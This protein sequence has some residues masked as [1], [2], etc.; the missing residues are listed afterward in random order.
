MGSWSETCGL[1]GLPIRYGDPVMLTFLTQTSAHGDD[2]AGTCYSTGWWTPYALP[3]CAEYA[4]YGGVDGYTDSWD[5]Q[6]ILTRLQ[7][8]MLAVGAGENIYHDYAVNPQELDSI[9]TLMRWIHNDRVFVKTLVH[10]ER[11]MLRLGWMM[12]HKRAYEW[13]ARESADYAD[14]PIAFE[15]VLKQGTEWYR[16]G[17]SIAQQAGGDPGAQTPQLLWRWLEGHSAVGEWKRL[18]GSGSDLDGY[19]PATKI[20]SYR[21]LFERWAA[22]LRPV[23]SP[24]VQ[25]LLH[26]MSQYLLVAR[27]MYRL[28]KHWSPQSGKGSQT[29]DLEY[30]QSWFAECQTQIQAKQAELD[31]W[32]EADD[33][34]SD[35]ETVDNAA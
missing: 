18:L 28:R 2:G 22:E 29:A 7:E 19:G 35:D 34:P 11:N 33:E 27:N 24:E 23:D 3:M 9:E 6:W 8:D 16:Q 17:L 10:G 25:E 14:R 26:S 20:N 5:T 21:D 15:Q 13:L 4:D 30:Y 1:T 32:G 31:A 12:C